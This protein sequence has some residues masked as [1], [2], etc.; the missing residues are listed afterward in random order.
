[1]SKSK[2]S[3][4][5]HKKKSGKSNS[6][7]KYGERLSDHGEKKKFNKN[8]HKKSPWRDETERE[9]TYKKLAE[10]RGG[11]SEPVQEKNLKGPQGF[12][13][14]ISKLGQEVSSENTRAFPRD[15]RRRPENA[16]PGRV[17]DYPRKSE[18]NRQDHRGF[19]N[20]RNKNKRGPVRVVKGEVQKNSRGFAFLLQKPEDIFIPPNFAA[21]LLTGDHVEVVVSGKENEVVDLKITKRA[22]KSF[23]GTYHAGFDQRMVMLTDRTMREEVK[24]IEAPKLPGLRHGNKVQVEITKSEFCC[25]S[26]YRRSR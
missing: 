4:K 12:L 25:S 24:I 10:K 19:K 14:R 2:H 26:S 8:S 15:E 21:P 13:S 1:M 22:M 18:Q 17:G 16:R 5:A 6:Q 3:F 23:I 9:Q 11:V 20:Q 7:K